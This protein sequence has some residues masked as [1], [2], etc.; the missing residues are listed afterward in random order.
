MGGAIVDAAAVAIAAGSPLAQIFRGMLDN[1]SENDLPKVDG[2]RFEDKMGVYGWM[3]EKTVLIGNRNLLQAHHI[4]APS[5]DVDQKI[6]RSG[7]FPVYIAIDGAP[8]VLFIVKYEADEN[9]AAEMQRLCATGMTVVVNP[10]DPNCT[11]MMLAD[12]FEVSQESVKVM[13]HNG[14]AAYQKR[15]SE[16]D[17]VSAPAAFGKNISGF[18]Y[19]VTSAVGLKS[20]IGLMTAVYIISAV[21]GFAA[22]GYMYF[23]GGRLLGALAATVYE[24]VVMLISIIIAKLKS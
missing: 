21:L 1:L 13:N 18:F 9:I 22:F 11:D 24:A 5:N 3:G 4:E 2:V 6:L 16:K 15:M 12:Y 17:S 14:I 23:I 19:A 20:K 7:Y 10:E 8:V